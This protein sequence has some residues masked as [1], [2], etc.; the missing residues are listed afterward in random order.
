MLSKALGEVSGTSISR[1]PE[2]ISTSPIA[3]TC[4]VEF[5]AKSQQG[6]AQLTG[7][8]VTELQL[9]MMGCG[10]Q[11]VDDAVNPID[12]TRQNDADATNYGTGERAA[13]NGHLDRF[14][15]L[16]RQVFNTMEIV[17]GHLPRGHSFPFQADDVDRGGAILQW[18]KRDRMGAASG[19]LQLDA[20][21]P[22]AG[23]R[24]AGFRTI[25]RSVISAK[26]AV[27]VLFVIPESS[28]SSVRDIPLCRRISLSNRIR[29]RSSKHLGNWQP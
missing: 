19:V 1:N 12:K 5:L 9:C 7:Q 8:Q 27:I 13:D 21:A 15:Q 18:K 16:T 28:A 4:S 20:G 10:W 23:G 3:A 6:N 14:C 17:H 22:S 26:S 25:P 29:V 11:P 2:A 24:N